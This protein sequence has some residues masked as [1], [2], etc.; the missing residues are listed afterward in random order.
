MRSEFCDFIDKMQHIADAD[1][2]II[3]ARHFDVLDY[4]FKRGDAPEEAYENYKDNFLRRWNAITDNGKN[5][6]TDGTLGKY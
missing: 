4:Y 1:K 5:T 2:V 6:E 3:Q